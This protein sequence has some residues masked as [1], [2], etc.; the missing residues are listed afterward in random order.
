[1]SS[2][3][4]HWAQGGRS[5]LGVGQPD[6]L[7]ERGGVIPGCHGALGICHEPVPEDIPDHGIESAP[8]ARGGTHARRRRAG[9]VQ[10]PAHTAEV[11]AHQGPSFGHE[12]REAPAAQVR[13]P[14]DRP[15]WQV[16]EQ[17][18]RTD[19]QPA[20]HALR[21][22]LT[23]GRQRPLQ[24]LARVLRVQRLGMPPQDQIHQDTAAKRRSTSPAA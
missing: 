4:W 7:P 1:M 23:L 8:I 6:A 5:Q 13:Q 19:Q 14:V 10:S 12:V 24:V 22:A 18:H 16:L 15:V 2:R 11:G 3:R 17:P 9:G 21:L 20:G